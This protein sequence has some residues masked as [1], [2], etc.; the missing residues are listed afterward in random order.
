MTTVKLAV[1]AVGAHN[2]TH[3][4]DD[5]DDDDDDYTS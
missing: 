4:D 1:S 5:D 2:P 3:D